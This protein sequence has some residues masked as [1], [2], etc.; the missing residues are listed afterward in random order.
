ML[1][2]R[3]RSFRGAPPSLPGKQA[4]SDV[5]VGIDW[6]VGSEAVI[7]ECPGVSSPRDPEEP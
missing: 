1:C 6:S 5:T 2:R 7:T 3:T 4:S